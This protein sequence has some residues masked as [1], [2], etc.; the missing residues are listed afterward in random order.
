MGVK[1][2]ANKPKKH[3]ANCAIESPLS[4]SVGLGQAVSALSALVSY[5]ASWPNLSG[6]R[7][8]AK[9]LVDNPK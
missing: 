5:S 8:L 2:Q 9:S 1:S 6:N 7:A 4:V 3:P